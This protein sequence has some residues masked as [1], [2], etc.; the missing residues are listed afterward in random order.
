MHCD[1]KGL[2][3]QVT[4]G[5][6]RK[7]NK[8]WLY[9]FK[10][11]G[12]ERQM[13]LGP[14]PDISLAGAR[15]LA[16]DARKLVKTGTDPI[17]ARGA[18][19]AATKL[20]A[21]LDKA[22]GMTFDQCRDAYIKAHQAGWGTEYAQDWKNSLE[23]HVSP[24]FGHLPV[25]AIDT[26]LVMKA[27]GPIWTD[28]TV[29]AAHIRNRVG[30]VL[31]WATSMKAR[32]GE[33]PARWDGHLKNLLP[34]PSKVHKV[35]NYPA[36]PYAQIGAFMVELRARNGMDARSL[37]FVILTAARTDEVLAARKSEFDLGAKMWTIPGHRMKR[38]RE[39]RVPLTE[40]AIAIAKEAMRLSDGEFVF[41]GDRGPR[42]SKNMLQNLLADMNE[43]RKKAGLP[44][45]T[46]PKD[47]R[48][49]V[50]HG[51]RSTF[52]DWATDWSPTP[53]EIVEAA[54]RGELVEAFPRDL[55][56][57]ALAHKLPDATEAAYRR[58]DMIEKRRRLMNRW[59]DYRAKPPVKDNLVDLPAAERAMR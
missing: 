17:D 45:W 18:Q 32:T 52:K 55:V 51:F 13:G 41:P 59:A 20:A 56:E 19:R 24:V 30:L 33:N 38:E 34:K 44:L 14:F 11:H 39:H 54:K 46:D 29:T 40:R 3:L 4:M 36:L 25:Q 28:I 6:D 58:T 47:N 35:R 50:P 43:A 27:L 21:D 26:E 5:D 53:A 42:Q 10:L 7:P 12:R 15:D 9:R 8:S 48:E 16:A 2:Y 31:D 1:G 57:V 22:K 49:I 23:Q 37:E